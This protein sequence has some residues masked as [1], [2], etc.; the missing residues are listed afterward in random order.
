M[1]NDEKVVPLSKMSSALGAN[2]PLARLPVVLLQV[3]AGEVSQSAVPSVH[4]LSSLHTT[5]LP[6]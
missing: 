6:E 2:A 5:P 4:S 1:P 3:A